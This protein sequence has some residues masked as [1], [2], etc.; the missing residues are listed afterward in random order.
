MH[1]GISLALINSLCTGWRVTSL[2]PIVVVVVVLLAS[3]SL[4]AVVG[5]LTGRQ[6]GVGVARSL[7]NDVQKARLDTDAVQEGLTALS[8]RLT[9]E[10]RRRSNQ[11]SGEAKVVAKSLEDEARQRLAEAPT[12]PA[13]SLAYERLARRR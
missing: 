8:A 1:A 11:A 3:T 9:S 7:R 6:G 2:P 5:W 4:A 10:I 12:T 13:V